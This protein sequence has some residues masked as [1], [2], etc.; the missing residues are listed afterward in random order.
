VIVSGT[1]EAHPVREKARIDAA[2]RVASAFFAFIL[3]FFLL[4]IKVVL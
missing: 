1:S 3:Q 4:K 2:I